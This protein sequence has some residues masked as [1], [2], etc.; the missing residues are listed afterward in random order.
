MFNKIILSLFASTLL[1]SANDLNCVPETKTTIENIC[2]PV[3]TLENTVKE[4]K[5]EIKTPT[6][7][8]NK[9]IKKPI[10]PKTETK[11][12]KQPIKP[13]I[14]T[15]DIKKSEI[16]KN[17]NIKQNDSIST[18]EIESLKKEISLLNNQISSLQKANLD[19]SNNNHLNNEVIIY[20]ISSLSEIKQKISSIENNVIEYKFEGSFDPSVYAK[21]KVVSDIL[22]ETNLNNKV[23]NIYTKGNE[24]IGKKEGNFLITSNGKVDL[25][26]VVEIK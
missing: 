2:K 19:N 26:K 14:D 17:L 18:K 8:I 24:I 5:T 25:S 10:S 6:T 13:K 7:V 15:K 3:K 4:V 11:P 9:E 12:V 23:V 22:P 16:D 1:L 20:L 21:Y